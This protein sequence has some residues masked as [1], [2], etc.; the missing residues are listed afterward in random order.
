MLPRLQLRQQM[1]CAPSRMLSASALGSSRIAPRSLVPGPRSGE[2]AVAQATPPR[3]TGMCCRAFPAGPPAVESGSLAL[4]RAPPRLSM[5]TQ[6]E[7]CRSLPAIVAPGTPLSTLASCRSHP[8][9]KL[10]R[11]SKQPLLAP[12]RR[13]SPRHDSCSW[14]IKTLL[15]PMQVLRSRRIQ[16]ELPNVLTSM[17]RE[18]WMAAPVLRRAQ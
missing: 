8:L 7:A 6:P 16:V 14:R 17:S 12:P 4:L 10:P 1:P 15:L 13:R 5:W 9:P 11:Y 3:K 18:C 2:L